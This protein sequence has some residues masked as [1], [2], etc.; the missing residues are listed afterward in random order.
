[1]GHA[2]ER[3]ELDEDP[4]EAAVREVR[5]EVGLEIRLHDDLR[6]LGAA[7]DR[8]TE[9]VPPKFLNR[10]GISRAHEHVTLVCFAR[11]ESDEVVPGGDE[12]SDA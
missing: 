7:S 10:H 1:M 9:L 2:H 12:R 4:N 3:I 5:E 8:Y 6:P 11:A